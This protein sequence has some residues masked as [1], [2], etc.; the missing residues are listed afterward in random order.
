MQRE[1]LQPGTTSPRCRYFLHLKLLHL[2]EKHGLFFWQN[3]LET[4]PEW[5]DALIVD[6]G[7]DDN[8][9]GEFLW[10]AWQSENPDVTSVPDPISAQ[11][12]RP[13]PGAAGPLTFTI[14][15]PPAGQQLLG[16][17][18]AGGTPAA[19]KLTVQELS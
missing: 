10:A 1:N 5:E 2:Q 12:R 14:S 11:P 8:G 4:L 3:H 18:P 19:V 7:P 16:P 9:Q 15:L 13:D 17:R 6:V